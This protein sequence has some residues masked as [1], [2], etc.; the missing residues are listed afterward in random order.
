[1]LPKGMTFTPGKA[2]TFQSVNEDVT[3]QTFIVKNAA[4]GQSLEFTVSGT[5]SMPREA[6]GAD[7]QQASGRQPAMAAGPT[8]AAPGCGRR[9]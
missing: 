3:A 9:G 6:Q 8:V 7:G 2:A 4:P 5:G 1:M